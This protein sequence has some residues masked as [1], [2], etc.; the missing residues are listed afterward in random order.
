MK[1]TSFLE[2]IYI[3][4]HKVTET[5]FGLLVHLAVQRCLWVACLP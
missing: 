3:G 1:D 2:G 5:E 4:L